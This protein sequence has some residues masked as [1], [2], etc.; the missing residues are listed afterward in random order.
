MRP[1]SRHPRAASPRPGFTLV[2][3]LLAI[4]VF[5]VGVLGLAGTSTIIMRQ[6]NAAQQQSQAATQAQARIDSLAGISCAMLADGGAMHR[7]IRHRW[8]I[9]RTPNAAPFSSAR[10]ADTVTW[11][12]RG[13]AKRQV[14]TTRIAC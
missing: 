2:E 13:E 10:I 8:T 9:E 7:G 3:M 11:V 14:Y 4:V 6:M 1:H 5:A 12:T